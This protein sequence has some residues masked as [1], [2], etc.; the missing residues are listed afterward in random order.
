MITLPS[1]ANVGALLL[2]ILYVYAVVG[3]QAFSMIKLK[4]NLNSHANFQHFGT[5]LLTLLTILTGE[6]FD[7]ILVDMTQNRS[8]LN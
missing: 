3:I 8:I 5:A 4:N 6:D 7:L 2:L 1:L